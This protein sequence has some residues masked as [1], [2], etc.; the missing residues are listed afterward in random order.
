MTQT[1]AVAQ[2][3]TLPDWNV[4]LHPGA[5]VSITGARGTFE[6][7]YVTFSLAGDVSLTFYDRHPSR[8]GRF[9]SFRPDQIKAIH[10]KVR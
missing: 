10:R 3:F 7:A 9:R 4:T 8:Q 5:T 2:Q 1:P 6:F